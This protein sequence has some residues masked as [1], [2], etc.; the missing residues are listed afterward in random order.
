MALGCRP[1][2][3]CRCRLAVHRDRDRTGYRVVVGGIGGREGHALAGV[4]AAG[5]VVGVV[6]AK[7]PATEAV[8]PVSVDEDRVWPMVMAPAVG[9]TDTVGVALLTVT[10]IEPVAVL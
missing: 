10:V 5:A 9:H 1:G 7:V 3:Y 2:R 6:Q 8:P 4:P